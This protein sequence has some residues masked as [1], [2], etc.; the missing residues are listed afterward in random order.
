M[1][2]A[3]AVLARLADA[4]AVTS[5]VGD[6]P[7][8]VYWNKRDQ[9]DP[10][11]AVVLGQ[12]SRIRDDGLE[13]DGDILTSRTQASCLAATHAEA[14]ALAKAVGDALEEE[15]DVD[16][17]LFWIADIEGPIDL[18][19]QG[20]GQAIVHEAAVDIILRHSADT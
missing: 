19:G 15:A 11:P 16:G 4:S 13:E 9:G 3:E 2:L 12:I 20:V 6:D 18:T 10:L 5:I 17:F 8:R 7:M 14:W 1:D